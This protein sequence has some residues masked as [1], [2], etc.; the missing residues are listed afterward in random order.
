MLQMERDK[1]TALDEDELTKNMKQKQKEEKNDK[2]S[3]NDSVLSFSSSNLFLT[4]F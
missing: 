4:F 2:D 3:H 1:K